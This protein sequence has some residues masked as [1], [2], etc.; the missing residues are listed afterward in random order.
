MAGGQ[1]RVAHAD[2]IGVGLVQ[3]RQVEAAGDGGAAEE[4]ALEAY[5][6]FFR[7]AD[8]LEMEGQLFAAL[9]QVAH[10]AIGS[11]MPRRPSYLPPLRT[12][13]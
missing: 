2:A 4:G 13:S 3:Q 6:F 9:V 11:R 5:A 8:D 10:Q 1:Q 12:V 7:E